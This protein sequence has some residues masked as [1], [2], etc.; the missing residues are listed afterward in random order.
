V[1][2]NERI[3]LDRYS[4]EVWITTTEAKPLLR[5]ALDALN[6]VSWEDSWLRESRE[7]IQK[8][9][10]AK[11]GIRRLLDMCEKND[12]PYIQWSEAAPVLR[13]VSEAL[14]DKF[15]LNTV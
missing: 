5:I 11:R 3:V 1:I 13:A 10:I 15:P 7:T 14:V 6:S 4:N 8:R 9:I 2:G 12:L